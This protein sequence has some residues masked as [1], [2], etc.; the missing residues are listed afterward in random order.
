MFASPLARRIARDGGIELSGLRGSGPNGRIV[1]ADVEAA[2]AAGPKAAAAPAPQPADAPAPAAGQAAGTPVPGIA[3]PGATPVMRPAPVAITAPH[4]AI[5]NSSVRKVIA[6]RLAESKQ[7]TPHF[8][9]SIDVELDALL[10]LRAQLNGKSP[11]EGPGAF[12]LSVN[13]LLIKACAVTLRRVPG[14]NATYTDDAI[15][16]YEDVDISVA[17]SIPD[18]L[19]T[20]IIRGA[21]RKG[22]AAISNEAKDLIAR[23]RA[24]KLKPAEFQGGGFS[25]SNMGMY[26]VKEFSAIIN[27][28]QGGILAVAAGLQRPMVRDGQLAVATV[29]TCT[30]SVDHRA[31]DGAMAAEWVAAFKSVVED[32]L[33][34]ML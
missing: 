15:L 32:P 3:V 23:A 21:D 26:G 14:V 16:Q 12:K 5:P 34:L 6:R 30:L 13:D 24:G 11:K 28:P 7:F 22:L 10:A 29:M 27:P 8:Y 19:I 1:R 4:S 33:S 17:V 20:P 2:R 25:I 9:V 31:I 18:G